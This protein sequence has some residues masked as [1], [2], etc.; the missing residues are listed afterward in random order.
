MAICNDHIGN[1]KKTVIT[2]YE[3][4]KIALCL[5]WNWTIF[6]NYWFYIWI[7]RHSFSNKRTQ[8]SPKSVPKLLSIWIIHSA[9]T[10]QI[11]ERV[12]FRP[13]RTLIYSARTKHTKALKALFS[14]IFSQHKT[15]ITLWAGLVLCFGCLFCFIIHFNLMCVH[16]TNSQ[17]NARCRAAMTTTTIWIMETGALF[18]RFFPL[19]YMDIWA[20]TPERE[21]QTSNSF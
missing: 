3:L 16:G 7:E 6:C 9:H 14:V 13:E 20:R 2:S 1:S 12:K 15:I 18:R 4:L 10:E 11:P 19:Y 21:R 8:P 17:T 5:R